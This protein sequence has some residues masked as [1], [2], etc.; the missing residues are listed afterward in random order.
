MELGT[1]SQRIHLLPYSDLCDGR[2]AMRMCLA[3]CGAM[4]GTTVDVAAGSCWQMSTSGKRKSSV[5]PA[6]QQSAREREHS[7]RVASWLKG[8][9][10]DVNVDYEAQISASL[11]TVSLLLALHCFAASPHLP[12]SLLHLLLA[13]AYGYVQPVRPF[14]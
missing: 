13:L 11:L 7:S 1:V 10:E 5:L 2:Q 3:L 6:M 12:Y 4:Q 8:P 14:W 9:F